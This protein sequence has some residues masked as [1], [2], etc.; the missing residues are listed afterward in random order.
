MVISTWVGITP[1]GRTESRS[2]PP[3]WTP[4]ASVVAKGAASEI[5]LHVPETH[6]APAAHGGEQFGE[7]GGGSVGE[8]PLPEPPQPSRS[9][10][11]K[12]TFT[13]ARMAP[14]DFVPRTCTSSVR[15]GEPVP[16]DV[17]DADDNQT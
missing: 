13:K 15:A 5:M 7:P 4:S 12:T 16:I 3:T 6:A 1:S 10:T 11:A 14:L 8:L 9:E 2:F 17:Q